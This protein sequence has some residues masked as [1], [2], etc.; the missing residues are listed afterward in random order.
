MHEKNRK[1]NDSYLLIWRTVADIPFGKVASYGQIAELAG[2]ARQARLV[3]YALHNI[4]R[5][6]N[7]PWHRVINA[8]GKISFPKDSEPYRRQL[9]RLAAEGIE[10]ID[11]RIDFSHYRWQPDLDEFLWKPKN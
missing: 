8:Q 11:G 6:L 5:G 9:E 2:L 1:T 10:L 3:G 7:I 4:P